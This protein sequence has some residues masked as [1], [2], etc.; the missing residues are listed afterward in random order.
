MIGEAKATNLV[1]DID[2]AAMSALEQKTFFDEN[3]FLVISG[4]IGTDELGKIL[5]DI[6][7]SGLTG[8]TPSPLI[9]QHAEG[10]RIP[11]RPERGWAVP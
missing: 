3:G 2:W 10:V 1:I 5:S 9:S 4:A 8:L 6:Q 11:D 7:S